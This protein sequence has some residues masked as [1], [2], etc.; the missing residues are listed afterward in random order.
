M[1]TIWFDMDGT[2]AD[3]Y[4]VPGWLDLLQAGDPSPYA[5]AAVMHNM[6][7][8]AKLL[9]RV[10]AAGYELGVI[11]WT[12]RNSTDEYATA[13]EAAKRRWLDQHLHSVH[14]NTINVVAYGTPKSTFARTSDDI[15]FDDEERN[16]D[17]WTG[18]AYTPD[19]IV[20]VL[21]ELLKG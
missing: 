5:E 18:T 21:K 14:F 10:Q 1:R 16:R 13:V 15:L 3:L 2:I 17:E 4:D 6:S 7:Q 9:N 20:T 12:A 11:S 8:L 19:N